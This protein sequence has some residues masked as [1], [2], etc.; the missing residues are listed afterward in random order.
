M[1]IKNSSTNPLFKGSL[2]TFFL[3]ESKEGKRI[4][5]KNII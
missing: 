4:I 1:P 2:L 3:K 5:I